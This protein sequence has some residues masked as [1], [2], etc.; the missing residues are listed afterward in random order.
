[1]TTTTTTMRI[2]YTINDGNLV[3]ATETLT[4]EQVVARARRYREMLEQAFRAEFGDD[5]DIDLTI[6]YRTS[7]SSAR[8]QVYSDD[9]DIDYVSL[10]ERADEIARQTFE[11]LIDAE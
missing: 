2:R 10:E 3:Y 5:A 1:M 8:P 6:Q 9:P 4:D 11:R 7:G